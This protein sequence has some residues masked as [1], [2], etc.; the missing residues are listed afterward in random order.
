MKE[1][2]KNLNNA[3]KSVLIVLVIIAVY[4]LLFPFIGSFFIREQT[5][6]M[7]GMSEMMGANIMSSSSIS[8]ITINLISLIFALGLGFLASL[9]LFKMKI[10]DKEY[11]I[12]RKALS[13]DK[14]KIFDEIKKAGEIT[15]DSLRFRLNWSKS[16]VSTILT[17]LD[18]MNL[19]QRERVGKTYKVYLQK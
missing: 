19:I 8:S 2:L 15:Q 12:L 10:E 1:T 17:D 6:M 9:Y 14:K 7:Q 4:F 18:K 13:D 11:K 3:S 16:K 5:P